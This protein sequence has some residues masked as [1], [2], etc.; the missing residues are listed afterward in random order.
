[1]R[2]GD[3]A[4]I[5]LTVT[6]VGASSITLRYRVYR[7]DA[8]DRTLCA[9]DQ[10]VAAAVDM[11]RLVGVAVPDGVVALLADLVEAPT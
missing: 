4:E 1:M 8:P 11:T 9:E 5:E 2:S 10:V 7:A 6:R 3:I